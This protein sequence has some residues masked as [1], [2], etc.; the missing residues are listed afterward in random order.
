VFKNP[1]ETSTTAEIITSTSQ[2]PITKSIILDEPT[3]APE[4]ISEN[5]ESK[6]EDD[7]PSINHSLS[8]NSGLNVE[9]LNNIMNDASPRDNDQCCNNDRLKIILPQNNNQCLENAK[10]AQISIPISAEKLS[11]VPMKELLNL[12]SL[13]STLSI[14]QQL[15]LLAEKYDL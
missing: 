2:S 3:E 5:T 6:L 8:D 9:L 14:L 15:I 12:S 1:I 4:N 13:R 7:A 10:H 11:S